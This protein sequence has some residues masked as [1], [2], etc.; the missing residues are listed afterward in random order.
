MK[1]E[2]KWI[3]LII[4]VILSY[5]G[6]LAFIIFHIRKE[7]EKA[8]DQLTILSFGLAISPLLPP[9]MLILLIKNKIM[10]RLR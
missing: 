9:M 4:Y 7:R 8:K 1:M 3:I 6:M 5:I 2:I 10:E